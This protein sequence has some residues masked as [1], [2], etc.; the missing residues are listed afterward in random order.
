MVDFVNGPSEGVLGSGVKRRRFGGD[1]GCR[2]KGRQPLYHVLISMEA[3]PTFDS[4]G[5]ILDAH[6]LWSGNLK[7]IAPSRQLP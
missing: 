4:Q 7:E 1:L 6:L 3:R 2:G 5:L